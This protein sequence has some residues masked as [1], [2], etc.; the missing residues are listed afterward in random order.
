MLVRLFFLGVED[1]LALAAKI[2]E[3]ACGGGRIVVGVLCS[4]AAIGGPAIGTCPK[5]TRI[6][7]PP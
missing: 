6:R 1:A 5:N 2:S 4:V 3:A 7:V